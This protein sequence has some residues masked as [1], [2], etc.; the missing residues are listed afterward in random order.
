MQG[1]VVSLLV[2]VCLNVAIL[3]YTRT[4]M[5]QAEIGLRTALG[6]SRGRIVAQ[7]FLEALVLSAVAALAGVGIAAFALREVTA[8]TRRSPRIAILGVVPTLT[9]RRLVCRRTQCTGRCHCRRRARPSGDRPAITDRP[10]DRWSR[11]KRH[12]SRKDLD[13]TDRRAGRFRH[14]ALLGP[15]CMGQ[16]TSRVGWS[17]IR[18]RRV[19]VRATRD[20]LGGGCG[21]AAFGQPGFGRFAVQ[22]AELVRRLEA[23]PRVGRIT[24]AM[25]EPG[26]EPGAR[27]EAQEVPEGLYAVRFNRVAVNISVPLTCRSSRAADLSQGIPPCKP[28]RTVKRWNGRGEPVTRAA[29]FRRQR[30]RKAPPIRHTRQGTSASTQPGRWYESSED[31]SDFPTGVSA[32]MDDSDF[33]VYHAA[34]AGQVQP[35]SLA[36]RIRGG[37]SSTFGQRSREIAASVD[38]ELHL[39]DIRSLEEALRKEQWIRRLEAGVLLAVTASVVLLSSASIYALMSFTVSQRR[40]E[41]GIRMASAPAGGASSRPSS[42]CTDATLRRCRNR[43]G[44][45][46]RI[47]KGVGGQSHAGRRAGRAPGRCAG[48]HDRGRACGTGSRTSEPQDRANRG[49]EGA[50]ESRHH[51]LCVAWRL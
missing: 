6:A 38:P 15:Q 39:R 24:F 33:K 1:L 20:R 23:E 34:A 19:P 10:A 32:G 18:C 27:I 48:Y 11:W 42:L 49:V 35:A 26:D 2:L 3:V 40:R 45:G 46:N 36:L 30:P 47:G 41:I 51:Q 12:A 16:P 14:R 22:Q 50:I 29:S 8:A 7:L 17:R 21:P 5:R 9:R 43:C 13:D 4:A 31:R 37:A 28:R 44:N 25:T